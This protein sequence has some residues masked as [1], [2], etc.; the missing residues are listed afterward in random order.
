[1]IFNLLSSKQWAFSS[2]NGKSGSNSAATYRVK[3]WQGGQREREGS[4]S[5]VGQRGQRGGVGGSGTC[6][7]ALSLRGRAQKSQ[8]QVSGTT[9]LHIL[10]AAEERGTFSVRAE[11]G[12][13]QAGW[14]PLLLRAWVH[15]LIRLLTPSFRLQSQ[16]WPLWGRLHQ[17]EALSSGYRA[18]QQMR[19]CPRKVSSLKLLRH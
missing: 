16:H 1:M 18:C 6:V 13:G 3:S 17:G 12:R 11:L 2:S 4:Q 14:P 8:P 9:P 7:P 19:L 5:Q 10:G 15:S